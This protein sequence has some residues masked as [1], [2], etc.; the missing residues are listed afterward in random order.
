[1]KKIIFILFL[2]VFQ[3]GIAFPGT[4]SLISN[5]TGAN[6]YYNGNEKV[7]ETAL[8]MLTEDSRLICEQP[9]QRTAH[10][11]TGTII[12]GIPDKQPE[13]KK[14]V[15]KY[16]ID[17]SGLSGQWEAFKIQAVESKGKSY[18]FILGSDPRGTAYGLLELSRHMGV[19]PW[20]WWADASAERKTDISYT[21]D[22][23][24]HKPS[25]QYRGI[26]IN[27]EDWGLTPWSNQTYEPSDIKGQIG[28][29]TYQQVFELLLRLRANTLW[30]AMHECSV[31]FYFTEGNKEMADTYGIFIGTSHCEPMMRNSAGE[32][33]A[34]GVGDYDYVNNSEN[35]YRFWEKRIKDVAGYANIYTI[36]MRGVH[37]GQMQGAKT[38][39]EQKAVLE[40]VL[41][42][43]RNLLKQYV[44]LDVTTIPQA[45]IPYKEVL[46]IY[47]AGLNVPDDVTLIW[48]DDNYG[49]IRHFPTPEEAQR[50]GGNGVYYHVS[51]WGRPHDYLWLGSTQPALIQQQMQLAY[52]SGIQKIW[53]LNVGDIKPIEYLTELFLDMAWD[54]D[55]VKQQGVSH[56]LYKWLERE[57]GSKNAKQLFPVMEEYCRLAH[58]RKPEFMGNTREEEWGNPN[59]RI[60]K[61]LPWD[62]VEIKNR[63][64]AYKQLSAKTEQIGLK[65]PAAQQDAYFEL[66]KYPV[67]AASLMN[68]KLLT[69]QLARHGMVDWELCEK[70]YENID[71]L[72]QRYNSLKNGKWNRMMNFQP[73]DLPVFK[74]VERTEATFPMKAR[75]EGVY[76]WNA[77]DHNNGQ[78]RAFPG[79]GYERKAAGVNQGDSLIFSFDEWTG[80]S[81]EIEIRLLPN[82]PV[83]GNELRF[84]VSIDGTM[85][86]VINY[87]TKGRS[88]EWKENVLRN[89][90]I[91]RIKLPVKKQDKHQLIFT[92]LDKGVI[93]DQIILYKP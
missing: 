60:V 86:P 3:A 65:I 10:I 21:P 13:I 15:S 37:D 47:N 16:K 73:R 63:M 72:T 24:V 46:D 78:V 17:I 64:T 20:I 2:S 43:Q 31:P 25:V 33:A 36:G 79:L 75:R 93:L 88:E 27:D 11:K 22:D 91:R 59:A 48:C 4:F 67:Q 55:T 51:Y 9:F 41:E 38:I 1:M 49:Y 62:E 71:S 90:A 81:A 57:F 12:V 32:W 85:S 26:F 69:A 14:L 18:L 74:R 35:V 50:K 40:R 29:R 45:F 8:R 89:Q 68:E 82:H 53:I 30:P 66:I 84:T 42:D 70:A 19:S 83:Q 92:S 7:V 58:I 23:L 34:E 54:I 6:I 28:P 56:H 44:N 77:M 5:N 52:D 76:K 39:E 80:D 61:D 87:E